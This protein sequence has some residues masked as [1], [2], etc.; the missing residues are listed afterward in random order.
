LRILILYTELAGYVLSSFRHFIAHHPES[1][2]LIVHFP[3]NPEA[4][5]VIDKIPHTSFIQYDQAN[6]HGIKQEL[7]LFNPDVIITSGWIN[8]NYIDY[9]KKTKKTIKKVIIIDNHWNANF[10]QLFF[11]IISNL[12]LTFLR[13]FSH[14]WVPGKPQKLYAQ[15]LG[16][17]DTK[18]IEGFYVA[19]TDL[20]LKTGALKLK[21]KGAFPKIILSVARYIPPKRFANFMQSFYQ[22]KSKKW[23]S[24]AIALHRTRS[25]I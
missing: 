23:Q 12:K 2:F 1:E 15:K 21:N 18:I 8:K 3:V 11:S 14:A 13:H 24:M 9:I 20:F 6:W 17:K 25:F 16:F 22:C 19:D 7:N 5:F 4:P 10:K